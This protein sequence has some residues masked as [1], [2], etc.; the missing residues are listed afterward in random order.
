MYVLRLL[1]IFVPLLVVAAIVAGSVLVLTARSDLQRSRQRVDGAWAPLRTL[2]DRRYLTLLSANDR[3]QSVP[4]PLHQL[5][6]QVSA[7]YGTW[8][9]L[10][11]HNGSV[12][13]EVVAANDLESLG[14][15]LVLAARAT[16]RL[17][18]DTAALAPT[19]A[20]AALTPPT[21]AEHFDAAV[22]SFE[23]ARSRPARSLAARI[24]GYGS[25]PT[26]DS[27]GFG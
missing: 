24:L 9:S 15:R 10:E 17:A 11:R 23:Q 14:R 13:A 27:S 3:L 7:A 20:L 4:G 21:A 2:L 6:E 5:V 1:R 26:Y 25:I 8:H 18:G 22:D 12:T 16:P 19:N